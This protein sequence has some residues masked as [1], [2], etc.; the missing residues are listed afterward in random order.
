MPRQPTPYESDVERYLATLAPRV[1]QLADRYCAAHPDACRGLTF[2]AFA[3]ADRGTAG[4]VVSLVEAQIRAG[5]APVLADGPAPPESA[6]TTLGAAVKRVAGKARAVAAEWVSNPKIW[7]ANVRPIKARRPDFRAWR[8]RM[9]VTVRTKRQTGDV[10]QST[11]RRAGGVFANWIEQGKDGFFRKTFDELAFSIGCCRETARK[12]VR[13]FEFHGLLDTFN[14]L[15]RDGDEKRRDKN[16]YLLNEDTASRPPATPKERLADRLNRWAEP[17]G[18]HAREW[19]LNAT[20]A[21]VGYKPAVR[22]PST[23]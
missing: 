22:R 8:T 3:A 23:A 21:F 20:P 1:R 4:L 2:A 5:V 18:L 9:H 13:F 19:G 14:V 11:M 17:F 10:L 7:L 12:I 16:L 6:G 15:Y